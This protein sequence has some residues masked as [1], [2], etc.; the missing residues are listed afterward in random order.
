MAESEAR[1]LWTD[2]SPADLARD[3]VHAAWGGRFLEYADVLADDFVWIGAL[4]VQYRLSKEET[5]KVYGGG[6]WTIPNISFANDNFREIASSGGLHV[7]C[8]STTVIADPS[9]GMA[10]SGRPRVTSIFREVGGG[11]RARA[12]PHVPPRPHGPRRR[13]SGAPTGVSRETIRFLCMLSAKFRDGMSLELRDLEGT[14]HVVRPFE[15]ICLEADRQYTDVRV[16]GSSFRMRQ[17]IGTLAELLPEDLFIELRRGTVANVGYVT[18]WDEDA[19]YLVDGGHGAAA[20]PQV[21]RRYS[22]RC[23][24][25]R[26]LSSASSRGWVLGCSGRIRRGA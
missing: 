11:A 20:Q 15:I 6:S 23:R 18:S 12:P 10:Y 2:I 22:T 21:Q 5:L 26:R 8:G 3:I 1:R 25:S 14:T 9:E 7:V 4:P 17:G 19:V 13:L 24:R 16:I